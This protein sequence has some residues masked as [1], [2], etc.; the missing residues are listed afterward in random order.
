MQ[1]LRK[2]IKPE[3]WGVCGQHMLRK[4]IN[5]SEVQKDLHFCFID[6]TM[7][8]IRMQKVSMRK[9]LTD[10]QINGKVL[11][12]LKNIYWKQHSAIP[13]YEYNEVGHCQPIRR[14]ALQGC[15]MSPE[16]FPHT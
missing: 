2:K 10:I 7:A 11:R 14:V 16:L 15:V 8:P 6:Y 1:R 3:I 4:L 5:S 9:M 13:I 12:N